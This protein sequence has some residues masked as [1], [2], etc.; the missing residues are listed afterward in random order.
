MNKKEIAQRV[1]IEA[2]ELEALI[3]KLQFRHEHLN[4]LAEAL[5]SEGKPPA[6]PN[7]KP[8]PDGKFRKLLNKVYGE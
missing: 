8:A 7:H 6:A 4:W 3:K 5:E 1:R 2:N